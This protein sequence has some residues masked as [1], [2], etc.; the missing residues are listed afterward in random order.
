MIIL[1]VVVLLHSVKNII[2]KKINYIW[3]LIKSE[4]NCSHLKIDGIFDGCINNYLADDLCP[5]K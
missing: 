1:R 2:I 4:Y 3:N 5:G